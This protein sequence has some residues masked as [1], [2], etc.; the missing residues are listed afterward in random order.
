MQSIFKCRAFLARRRGG[1][2][3]NWGEMLI[4]AMVG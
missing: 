3:P 2:M 4:A 1:K